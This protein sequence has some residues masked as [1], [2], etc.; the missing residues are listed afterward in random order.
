MLQPARRLSWGYIAWQ[1]ALI[2][3]PSKLAPHS[4]S[5]HSELEY[6]L[7]WPAICTGHQASEAIATWCQACADDSQQDMR[8]VDSCFLGICVWKICL[9]EAADVQAGAGGQSDCR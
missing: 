9:D 8:H 2:K 3:Q 5:R 1:T 4:S 6:L 7:A